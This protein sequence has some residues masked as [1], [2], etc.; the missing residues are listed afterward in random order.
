MPTTSTN[1][2]LIR[3]TPLGAFACSRVDQAKSSVE[4]GMSDKLSFK[5]YF[6]GNSGVGRLLNSVRPNAIIRAVITIV[7]FS[8]NAESFGSS[9]HVGS[10]GLKGFPPTITD[11]NPPSSIVL[12]ARTSRIVASFD[13]AAP[14]FVKRV[15][16]RFFA[17]NN[18]TA[19][20]RL[21]LPIE[22]PARS[23]VALANI[24]EP[25]IDGVPAITDAIH[26]SDISGSFS[27]PFGLNNQS[28]VA[29]AILN[30]KFFGHADHCRCSLIEVNIF[31]R[32]FNRVTLP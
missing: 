25:D 14:C 11:S 4:F 21:I 15:I 20:T 7:V 13:Y 16:G 22:A 10:E 26:S 19:N 32:N 27:H 9:P 30:N 5:K 1:H 23:G 18:L 2:L 24:C 8:L 17:I 31:F 29:G 12:K 28:S 6:L 3:P